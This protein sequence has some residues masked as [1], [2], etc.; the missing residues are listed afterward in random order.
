MNGYPL[1]II[2]RGIKEANIIYKR[3]NNPLSQSQSPKKKKE[4]YFVFIY[5]GRES[6]V[7]AQ[8]IKQLCKKQ[9]PNLTINIGF[10]KSMTLKNIFL[11]RQKGRDETKTNKKLVYAINCKDCDEKYIGETTRKK[12]TRIKEHINDIK[13]NKSTSLI[14]QHC[15][16]N[17][18]KMD[19]DNIETLALESMWKRRVIKESLLTQ[20]AH[21]KAINEVKHT[22]KVFD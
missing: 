8:R 19:F 11:P 1:H 16:L 21:G 7:L 14:A 12:L 18:H 4:I 9:L 3:V 17:K 2:Q 6:L 10:R 13:K 15:N 5:Y 22:L 20:Y